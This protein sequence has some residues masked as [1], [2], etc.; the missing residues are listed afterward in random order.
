MGQGE[1]S[2]PYKLYGEPQIL[3]RMEGT[4]AGHLYV[5]DRS[6]KTDQGICRCTI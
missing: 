2:R 3:R 6:R 5:V 4:K 1:A